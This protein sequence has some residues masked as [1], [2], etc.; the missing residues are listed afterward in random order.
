MGIEP[1]MVSASL[2]CVC[3]QRLM[4][5]VCKSCKQT[6]TQEGNEARI[7]NKALTWTGKVSK[8]GID[9]CPS[10]GGNGYKGR[11]GS[12]ELMATSEEVI[13]S[14]NAEEEAAVLK[15][16]AMRNG[17]MTLHQDCMLKV[18]EGLTT[19]E[20]ALGTVP[21]DMEEY[22]V[23]HNIPDEKPKRRTAAAKTS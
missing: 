4:R 13:K 15:K 3:A 6:Y 2:V 23:D 14:I 1:F 9:G 10:C 11:G 18:K 7:M 21:P 16:I 17:M 8:A 20:E 22:E 19:M 12:H 5:R